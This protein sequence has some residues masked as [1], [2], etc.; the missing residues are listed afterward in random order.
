M[1]LSSQ[2]DMEIVIVYP[3]EEFRRCGWSLTSTQTHSR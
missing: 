1:A 3:D 2:L